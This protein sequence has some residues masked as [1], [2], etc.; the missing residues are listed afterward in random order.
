MKPDTTSGARPHD[1]LD[2]LAE[3]DN[4]LADIFVAW[5]ESDPEGADDDRSAV[6]MASENGTL[7]KLVI[8]HAAVRVAAKR[9]I[10][11]VLRRAGHDGLADELTSH[12]AQVCELL[13][14]LYEHSRGVGA[15]ELSRSP[16]FTD[17]VAALGRIIRA[18]LRSE[19]AG[20]VPRIAVALG[21]LRSQ[22]RSAK[23]VAAH[24]PTHPATARSWYDG[25][26]FLVRVHALYDRLRGYPWANSGTY[27]NPR[28][29]DRY[30]TDP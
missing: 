16:Q 5:D 7:G 10:E 29:A 1:S 24:A 11:R 14:R 26:P 6:R 19:P 20:L 3:Q 8:E 12:L 27:A 25:I 13:D 4:V 2:L 15:V 9:D 22:L 23:H 17:T 28:L 18:E 30:D 21:D